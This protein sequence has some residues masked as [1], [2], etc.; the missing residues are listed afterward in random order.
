MILVTQGSRTFNDY[1]IFINA[2]FRVL[3]RMEPDDKEFHIYSVGPLRVNQMSEE[4]LNVSNFRARGIKTKMMRV[5]ES[6]VRD[7]MSNIDYV[8]YFCAPGEPVSSLID[9]AE[10]RGIGNGIHRF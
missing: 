1:S 3:S 6:Y 9:L 8:A 4:Y 7:H 10:E 2:M 5:N